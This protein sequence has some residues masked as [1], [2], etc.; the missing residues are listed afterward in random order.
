MKAMQR[1]G[2]FALLTLVLGVVGVWISGIGAPA[3]DQPNK[4]THYPQQVLIIRHAEKTGDKGDVHL[5]KQGKERADVIY[6]LFEASKDRQDPFPN[7]DFIFAAS[8]SKDSSRPLETVT[9]L[10]EKLKLTINDKYD[11]KLP[12]KTD[13]KPGMRELREEIFGQEKYF[14]KTILIAWRHGTIPELAK[15]LEATKVPE[16]WDDNVFDRVW[17]ISYDDQG[18]TTFVD[19]PQRLMSGDAEK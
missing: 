15:T 13:K 18:K 14:G 8:N 2:R 7:P 17:Q 16:K 1:L 19:R 6:K 4:N 3:A 12:D 5:S 9:T 11:S 10:A